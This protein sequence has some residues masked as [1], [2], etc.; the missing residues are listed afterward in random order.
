LLK[1]AGLSAPGASADAVPNRP[2]VAKDAIFAT[3]SM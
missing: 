2:V 3:N 1:E